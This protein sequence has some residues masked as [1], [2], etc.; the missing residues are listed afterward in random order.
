MFRASGVL[1]GSKGCAITAAIST[2]AMMAYRWARSARW[3]IASRLAAAQ[4]EARA[5]DLALTD[6]RRATMSA[7]DAFS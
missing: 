1:D 4:V 3:R 7:R 5:G 6:Q 2:A